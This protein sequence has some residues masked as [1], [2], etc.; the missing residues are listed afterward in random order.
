MI[1]RMDTRWTRVVPGLLLVVLWLVPLK[2]TFAEDAESA[3]RKVLDGQVSAWNKGDIVS[4]MQGYKDSPDTTFIGKTMRQGWQQ[5]MERYKASYSTKD[6]MGTL[7][8]SDLKIR[9]LGADYAVATGKYHLTRTA[10]GGGD[11]TGIFSL[12][13]EKSAGGWKIILDHTS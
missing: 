9:M 7:E 3:I 2:M 5:V 12:V 6:A 1:R 8:F 11:A 10:A 4:F 13:W